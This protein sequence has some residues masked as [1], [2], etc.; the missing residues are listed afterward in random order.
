MAIESIRT[1]AVAILTN[2][3][4]EWR[5]IAAEHATVEGLMRGYAAPLAAIPAVCQ[6]IGFT[7][8]RAGIVPSLVSAIVAWVLA[9]VG[10][11]LVAAIIERLAPTFQS[12]GNP[13]QTLKL[14]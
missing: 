11:W 14:V 4:A 3:A 7:V 9:L 8:A 1:R 10:A 13:I 12:S 5:T 2:P 6:F